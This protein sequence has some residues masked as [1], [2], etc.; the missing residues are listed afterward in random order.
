LG[1]FFEQNDSVI[2]DTVSGT[3][4]VTD[5]IRPPAAGRVK[6]G[7]SFWSAVADEEI[8]EGNV[9]DIVEKNDLTV[10]VRPMTSG[11]ENDHE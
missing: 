6:Y 10:K 2:V 1:G 8:A 7:G 11:K 9:V 5:A 3:G 4:T